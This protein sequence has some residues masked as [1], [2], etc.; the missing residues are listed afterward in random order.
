MATSLFYVYPL[1][2]VGRIGGTLGSILAFL[3]K[4]STVLSHAVLGW[5]DEGRPAYDLWLSCTAATLA[6]NSCGVWALPADSESASTSLGRWL[7]GTP[8]FLPTLVPKS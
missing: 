7:I 3:L 1:T 2:D 8:D 5:R 4:Y 6:A